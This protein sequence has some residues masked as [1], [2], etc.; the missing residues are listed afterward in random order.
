MLVP[1]KFSELSATPRDARSHWPWR[2]LE[3]LS[4]L[5]VVHS[6]DVAK[7]N[8]GPEFL[9]HQG[10]GVFD[11]EAVY[12]LLVEVG[13]VRDLLRFVDDGDWPALTSTKFVEAGVAGDSITPCLERAGSF[14]PVESTNDG[15]QSFLAGVGSV[16]VVTGHASAEGVEPFVV[17]RQQLVHGA[18]VAGL[19]AGHEDFV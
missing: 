6:D 5:C 14:E 4:D 7:D 1:E 10:N 19:G 12:D 11:G 15:H 8:G 9:G 17:T 16:S 2:D 3:R 13:G 18:P